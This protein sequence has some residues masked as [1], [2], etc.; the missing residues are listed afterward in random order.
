VPNSAA[1]IGKLK[2]YP[3]IKKADIQTKIIER[4][5]WVIYPIIKK[6]DIQ[7]KIIERRL[8]VTSGNYSATYA[9]GGCAT[10]RSQSELEFS[11]T[12]F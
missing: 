4:R 5:L 12:Y 11:M 6:A 8:W 3:I 9:T 10:L 7:T 2:F 1:R